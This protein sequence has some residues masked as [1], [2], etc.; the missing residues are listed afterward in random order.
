MEA[1]L[2]DRKLASTHI[3]NKIGLKLVNYIPCFYN[4]SCSHSWCLLPPILN[5]HSV[6]PLR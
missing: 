1:P 2:V 6:F 3:L 4:W 5:T